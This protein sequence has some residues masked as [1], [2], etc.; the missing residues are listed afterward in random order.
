MR[1][2]FAVFLAL[3]AALCVSCASPSAQLVS[4]TTEAT[5]VLS[6]TPPPLLP[7]AE[8]TPDVTTEAPPTLHIWWPD[9]LAPTSNQKASL[10]LA[11]YVDTF[12]ATIP[13]LTIEMRL[14]K[15]Q[16]SGGVI[17]T[18]RTAYA[19]APDAM[20]DI[21]L[22]RRND[23]LAA[24][25]AG[26]IQPIQGQV[27]SAVLGD[28]YPT[29]LD[30]GRVNG[31]L[32]GLA[33]TLDVEQIAY[34]PVVLSGSFAHFEDVLKDNQK[35]VFPAGVTEGL[36]DV[37]LLQYISAGGT[38]N[39]L[40]QGKPNA[41]ALLTILTFY[42][43]A[44]DAG[45]IDRSVLDY[46]RPDDYLFQLAQGKFDAGMI[47]SSQYLNLLA[48]GQA[49]EAAPI[50]LAAGE[51]STVLNGWMWVV[52]NKN[53]DQQTLALHFIEWMLEANRLAAY[54]RQINMLPARRA[55]MRLWN[56]G[57]FTDLANRLLANAR[58]PLVDGNA[59]TL[60]AM[61]N[62]LAAVISGQRTPEEAVSDVVEQGQK[63]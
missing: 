38:L 63:P 5:I 1:L 44:V 9:S 58:L 24:V 43:Q 55:A 17:E 21:T 51:P 14:K 22:L 25:D 50:P 57:T 7:V 29:A 54:S 40:I 3:F 52:V 2:V 6:M 20:P 16:D 30:L 34:R 41:K 42:K 49:F 45:I 28:L 59:T 26:F 62:A 56:A 36:S 19:V 53:K 37:L 32:Y 61:E 4:A 46:A 18:L 48:N 11:D 47:T 15:S 31:T 60:R 8:V 13:E 33:Y 27:T 39:E 35:F 23:M 10:M 12:R